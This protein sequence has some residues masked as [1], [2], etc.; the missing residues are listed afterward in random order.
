M[1]EKFLVVDGSSLIHR[2]FFALPPLMTQKGVHTGAVYGLCNMLLK[3]I[4]DVQPKWMLVAFDKSRTTFRTALYNEYKAQRKPTPSELSEQFPLARELLTAMNISTLELDGYEADDIIG[5]FAKHTADRAEVIIVTG[6]RDELQL[7]DENVKVFYTKRGISDIQVFDVAEFQANYEGLK[8]LQLIDLKGLMGDA[9]D[10]IPGVPGVGPKTAMKLIVEYQSVENVLD[11]ID[12]IAGKSLKEKLTANRDLALLSKKL[13][14]ICTEVPLNLDLAAYCVEPMNKEAESLM[15]ELEFRNLWSRFSLALG[16]N[17]PLSFA[18]FGEEVVA[19]P[20]VPPVLI[21]ERAQAVALFTKIKAAHL[22]T[23]FTTTVGGTIPQLYLQDFQLLFAQQTYVFEGSQEL[24]NEVYAWLADGEQK[25]IV[26]ESKEIIKA[27]LTQQVEVQGIIHDVTLA[28]YL[29]EPGANTYELG[30]LTERYLG[31]SS[32]DALQDLDAV[33]KVLQ[34]EIKT[35]ALT[36]LYENIELPLAAVLARIELYGLA[37]DETMLATITEEFRIKLLA[38]EKLA[39]EE[40]GSEFNLK[41]PKQLGVLLFE[42]LGLPALKKTKTGYSTD[43]S[44]LEQ[45]RGQHPIITTILEHRQLSKLYSTYL[46]GLRPLI[47]PVTRRVHTHFQQTVT[48]TGRLSSTEPNLQNIPTRT[49][50]GKRMRTMFVPGAGYDWLLSC[51][52]SQV[53]LRVLAHIAE[54]PLLLDSFAQGQD[55]HARTAAEVFGLPLA[56]VTPLLRSKAK[57]VNFGIVYGISDYG[58]SK[59][60]DISRAEAAKYIANYFARYTGVQTYMTQ[61]IATAKQQGYVTTLFGRRRYLPDINNANFNL[62]SFAERTAINTPI[63]GTAADII[64][65]AMINVQTALTQGGFQ[66]RLLLQVHDELVLEVVE[67]E[68]EKVA[69]LVKTTME[70]AANLQVP[71]LADVAW[72]KNW[73]ETK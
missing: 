55:V 68:R 2:A 12:E 34:E 62:R 4:N 25:K 42:Q 37:V 53:E 18:L 8:P 38:L 58:L 57:A 33:A 39:Y 32:G 19:P 3:L 36:A 45:L 41:S 20:A 72:G 60:L 71:L 30:Q 11:H 21:T 47:N 15:Q 9:S 44:V 6:D 43:V 35:K 50:I 7:L 40:A 31:Q 51:D 23:C 26:S 52:Y 10:N 24:W 61:A 27:C 16:S 70:K 13:A 28:A 17:A 29:L 69:T 46:E 49:E 73:A 67:S 5:T 1:A 65:V 66:S 64:K 63:Q 48:V 56:E 22:P 59:Q 54:D 14:T